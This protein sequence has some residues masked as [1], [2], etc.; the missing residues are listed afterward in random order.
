MTV[1][2]AAAAAAVSAGMVAVALG[3][4]AAVS[5][6]ALAG[7]VMVVLAAA[8]VVAAAAIQVIKLIQ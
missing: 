5:A 7:A 3:A 1:D 8:A 6:A 2:E 4:E